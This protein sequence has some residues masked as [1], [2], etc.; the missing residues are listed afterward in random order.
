[1]SAQRKLTRNL[2]DGERV[3]FADRL[4]H[5]RVERV[6]GR[7]LIDDSGHVA[8]PFRTV[9]TLE[10]MLRRGTISPEM[11]QAGEEFRTR[12]ALGQ[13]DSLKAADMARVGGGMTQGIPIGIRAERARREVWQSI[14]AAGGI[15]SPGGSV[16]W[17][18]LGWGQSLTQWAHQRQAW[19]SQ[20]ISVKAASGIL[21]AALGALAK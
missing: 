16:L 8:Q 15:A 7:E 9:D 19:C 21:V 4:R 12:F 2:T 20:E 10:M 13:L 17:H 1:M 6:T 3:E 11:K 14:R 5:G 18:V